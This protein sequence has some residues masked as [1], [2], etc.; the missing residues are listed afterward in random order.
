[1]ARIIIVDDEECIR[2]TFKEFLV[3]EGH[4]V[5]VAADAEQAIKK[6]KYSPY[7]LLISDII[8]PRVTGVELLNIVSKEFPDMLT[9]LI[10]G[11]PTLDTATSAVREGAFDYL[12][13]PVS[14]DMLLQVTRR[15]LEQLENLK[16][17]APEVSEKVVDEKVQIKTMELKKTNWKLRK[18]ISVRKKTEQELK[19]HRDF[20]NKIATMRGE[21]LRSKDTLLKRKIEEHERIKR[22]KE[23][24]E[25]QMIQVQKMEALGRFSGGIAHDF[26]NLLGGIIANIN[27]AELET[28]TKKTPFLSNAI[29][30][31]RRA[32]D[33]VEK[34][35][36]FS[37]SKPVEFKS[38]SP[39]SVI[40]EAFAMLR[41][42]IDRRIRL[43]FNGG[44]QGWNILADAGQIHQ[45]IVNLCLNS[46][47]AIMELIDSPENKSQKI[48]S[49]RNF[50]IDIDMEQI[51]LDREFVQGVPDARP[52]RYVVIRISDNGAGMDKKT[53]EH[54]F[55][56]FFTTKEAGR[57]T[58]L[59]LSTVFGIVSNHKGWI[60]VESEEGTGTM[61]L[62]YLPEAKSE[63][64][65]CEKDDGINQKIVGGSETILLVDD[66]RMLLEVG[67]AVLER[68]GYEVL[69]A[70]NG[71]ECLLALQEHER[72]IKLVILD[73]TM[74]DHSGLEILA[75]ARNQYPHIR[76]V[77][78]SGSASEDI[79][80]EFLENGA[81]R[82]I[83]KPYD[84]YE[85]QQVVRE[86]LD[87]EQL[88]EAVP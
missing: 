27:M 21:A 54:I 72:R 47:D 64:K 79:I 66:E 65:T 57:G 22:E 41:E 3:K 24:L 85:L 5:E 44:E 18:E 6:I 23:A 53:L 31:A 30:A 4:S 81:E 73:Q 11:Q 40:S 88:K 59:G 46:R 17:G 80:K 35:L 51:V 14:K 16:N 32:A 43:K 10:T 29:S 9:I 12:C 75:M 62:I 77:M 78:M 55:E 45:I 42:V 50:E 76:F 8:L 70:K 82:F 26:N 15:A 69:L 25:R 28:E 2:L 37:K 19:K 13:K 36:I 63:K 7:D 86:V 58:G 1:M 87:K 38:V 74:P 56:P 34:L 33:L 71:S 83:A 68:R 39:V 20:L 67:K 49:A 84:I 61:F 52:G 60:R 48:N